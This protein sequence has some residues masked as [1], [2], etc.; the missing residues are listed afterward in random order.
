M[1]VEDFHD[2]LIEKLYTSFEVEEE[3]KEEEELEEIQSEE[4]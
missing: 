3:E 1:G 4:A 2:Y